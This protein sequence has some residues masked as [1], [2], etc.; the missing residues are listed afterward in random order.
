M[1]HSPPLDITHVENILGG[2][3]ITMAG[4]DVT[5]EFGY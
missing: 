5:G 2:L 4:R 3:D 1:S